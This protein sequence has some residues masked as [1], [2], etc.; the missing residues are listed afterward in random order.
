MQATANQACEKLSASPKVSDTAK[1]QLAKD[2]KDITQGMVVLEKQ[3]QTMT[4]A[5]ERTLES[6]SVYSSLAALWEEKA[7][8]L[9]KD[10]VID[11][12]LPSETRQIPQ[13]QNN[14][15]SIIFL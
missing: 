5:M 1:A 3:I 2:Y 8:D 15:D 12:N 4:K 14:D 13:S 9:A 10:E 11:K 6:A 7:K